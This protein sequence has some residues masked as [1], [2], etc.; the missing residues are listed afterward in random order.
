M[1]A[2]P[3]G[4]STSSSRS[5][6]P[7]SSAPL[8]R[9][10]FWPSGKIRWPA[11]SMRRGSSHTS[12]LLAAMPTSGCLRAGRQERGQPPRLGFGIVIEQRDELA[13]GGGDSLVIGGAEAAVFAVADHPRAELPLRHFRRTVGRTVI[14]HDCF[15]RHLRLPRQR[16]EARAQQ[17]LPVPIDHHHGDQSI[18]LAGASEP[19]LFPQL[20]DCERTASLS[21]DGQ[22]WLCQS[23]AAAS[24]ANWT[25]LR[26]RRSS[27]MQVSFRRSPSG[28]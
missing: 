14:H 2:Q 3:S 12:T 26:T 27:P 18:M 11:L 9:P 20:A 28:A 1:A 23:S 7:R 22:G 15:E 4:H 17:F 8:P 16:R 21:P 6:W 10:R 25:P 19:R 24:G 5:N 13:A